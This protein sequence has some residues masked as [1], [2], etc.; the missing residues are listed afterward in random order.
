[1]AVI[2]R[3]HTDVCDRFRTGC[4][5][6][7]G[8]CRAFNVFAVGTPLVMEASFRAVS[9]HIEL[10]SLSGS[11]IAYSTGGCRFKGIGIEAI[12]ADIDRRL[13]SASSLFVPPE[14]TQLET[15]KLSSRPIYCENMRLPQ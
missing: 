2:I 5:G 4:E 9:G 10:R 14:M 3:N 8:F 6:I 12:I 15:E 7:A 1:M 11:K 13:V